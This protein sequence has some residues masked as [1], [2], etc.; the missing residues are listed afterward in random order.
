MEKENK[1]SET[2]RN[3]KVVSI[4]ELSREKASTESLMTL[5]IKEIFLTMFLKDSGKSLMLMGTL[6]L[7]SGKMDFFMDKELIYTVVKNHK[8]TLVSINKDLNMVKAVIWMLKEE[9]SKDFGNLEREKA[10]VKYTRKIK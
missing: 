3:F 7:D 8:N 10:K 9:Y 6:M 4:M 2:I 1:H 5:S